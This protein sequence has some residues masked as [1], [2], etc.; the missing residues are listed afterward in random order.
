MRYRKKT[1][2]VDRHKMSNI[3]RKQ[4]NL[5]FAVVGDHNIIVEKY[6]Y[7]QKMT[8]ELQSQTS[9]EGKSSISMLLGRHCECLEKQALLVSS[10]TIHNNNK[11]EIGKYAQIKIPKISA[12]IKSYFCCLSLEI[13]NLKSDYYFKYINLEVLHHLLTSKVSHRN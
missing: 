1:M 7:C 10:Q 12:S 3:W 11:I 5:V 8:V 2:N 13:Q 9:K 4:K 6:F